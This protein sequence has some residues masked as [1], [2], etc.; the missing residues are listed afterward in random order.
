MGWPLAGSQSRTV[1]SS[2]A[3]ASWVPSGENATAF[4]RPVVALEGG[5]GLAAGRVPEPHRPVV[6]GAGERAPVGRE[7][8]RV[9]PAGVALEDAGE[10]RRGAGQAPL[11][12]QVTSRKERVEAIGV[13]GAGASCVRLAERGGE[14]TDR[15]LVGE[16]VAPL[17]Q[18]RR[19]SHPIVA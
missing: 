6:A 5:G 2:P 11:G 12:C 4:T 1:P 9:H 19:S 18:S 17:R 10:C 13:D 15:G 7:R 16:Q 3:L 8:H 14:V